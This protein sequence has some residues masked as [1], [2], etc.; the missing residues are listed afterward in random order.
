MKSPESQEL[1]AL[2]NS[3][4]LLSPHMH[5]FP[6][7]DIHHHYHLFSQKQT[8]KYQDKHKYHIKVGYQMGKSP[9]QP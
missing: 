9:G 1:S 2:H 4:P 8:R 3:D 7:D 6:G 5:R